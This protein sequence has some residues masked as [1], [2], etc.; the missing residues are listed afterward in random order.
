MRRLLV[1]VALATASIATS[2]HAKSWTGFY[3]GANTGVGW[4]NGSTINEP[5]DPTSRIFFRSAFTDFAPGSFDTAFDQKGWLGGFQAG[6][7]WQAGAIVWG[8]EADLQKSAISGSGSQRAFLTPSLFGS[9]FGFDVN[10]QS[11]LQWFGTVRGRIGFLMTP[12]LMLYGTGGLS[13]GEIESSG[14]VV[15]APKGPSVVA[16]GTPSGFFACAATPANPTSICYAG[17]N[18]QMRMGWTAGLGGEWKLDSKWSFKVEYQYVQLKGMS[19]NLVS[20]SPPSTPGVNTN[21]VFDD[22]GFNV[23]RVGLNYTFN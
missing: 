4:S 18:S 5:V 9:Y 17:S 2:A 6:F 14:S 3:L 12:N 10:A 13:Y 15:L 20:P 22:Q 23:V 1:G 16:V 7:N 8:V 21:F 11:E 19:V